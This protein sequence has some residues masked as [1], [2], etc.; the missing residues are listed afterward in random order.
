MIDIS[1]IET[2][3]NMDDY[4][5][6]DNKFPVL[7]LG[8][9]IKNEYDNQRLQL[10]KKMEV[11]KKVHVWYNK[12]E[13]LKCLPL[14]GLF[15]KL[16][17]NGNK[18]ANSLKQQRKSGNM[19]LIVYENILEQYEFTCNDCYGYFDG[20]VYPVDFKYFDKLTDDKIS[21]DKKILQH[22]LELDENKFD[23]QKFGSFITLILT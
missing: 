23:F 8:F 7:F 22:L 18:I 2:P 14:Y 15:L 3:V 16:N 6:L 21:K 17:E 13:E 12:K 9:I 19:N 20:N 4:N 11:E 5:P 1:L 10:N